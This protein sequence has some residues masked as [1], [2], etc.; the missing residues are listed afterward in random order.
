MFKKMTTFLLALAIFSV[1]AQAAAPAGLKAAYDELTYN[2][3]VDWDQQDASVYEREM[4]A[5]FATVSDLQRAGLTSDEMIA[6]AS[7]QVRDARTA[8]DLQTAFSL[9][10]INKMSTEEASKYVL[11][12]L[13]RSSASGASWNG[14]AVR[15]LGVSLL[16]VAIAVGVVFAVQSGSGG[17]N[18]GTSTGGGATT[19]VDGTVSCA[20]SCAYVPSSTCFDYTTHSFGFCN[21][22]TCTPICY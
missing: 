4:K 14:D 8:R 16:I 12:A 3:S 15:N 7:T 17:K 2:L 1:Q 21:Q 9:I 11:D 19:P 20:D 6:F 13:R 18:S 22:L 10:I 5:F